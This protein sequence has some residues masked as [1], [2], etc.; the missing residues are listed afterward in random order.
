[1]AADLKA[2]LEAFFDPFRL[3]TEETFGYICELL[4]RSQGLHGHQY[5]HK[6]KILL[7]MLLRKAS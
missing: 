1:M 4:L 7:G 2:N 3:N 6:T 5:I